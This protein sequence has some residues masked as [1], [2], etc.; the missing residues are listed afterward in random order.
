MYDANT[1]DRCVSSRVAIN[2]EHIGVLVYK[3][4]LT[5]NAAQRSWVLQLRVIRHLEFA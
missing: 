1:R 2:A 5:T 3:P 4:Q